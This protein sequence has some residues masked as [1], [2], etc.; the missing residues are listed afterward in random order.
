MP[1]LRFEGG[2]TIRSA[3][4]AQL[5]LREALAAGGDVEVDCAGVDEAD[6]TFLQLLIAAHRSAVQRGI[7]LRLAPPPSPELLA[8]VERAGVA[9]PPGM[10]PE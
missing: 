8:V 9:M 3:A 4:E 5:L 10:M 6:I 1:T 2:A 7:A